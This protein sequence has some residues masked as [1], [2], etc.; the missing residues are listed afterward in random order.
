MGHLEYIAVL[1][2]TLLATMPRACT[3]Q[4]PSTRN[5]PTHHDLRTGVRERGAYECWP[6]P[7]I[8]PGQ[9]LEQYLDNDGTFGRP[10][11]SVQSA[12]ILRG[13]VYCTG[14]SRPIVV[15]YRTVGC[16]R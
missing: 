7:S 2:C 14:G 16:T 12:R 15:D 9:T 6:T 4:C 10:E 11:R 13:L 5:C 1:V 3:R 8:A